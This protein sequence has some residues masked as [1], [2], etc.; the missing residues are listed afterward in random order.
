MQMSLHKVPSWF[1]VLGR[2]NEPFSDDLKFLLHPSAVGV[3]QSDIYDG[4]RL[5]MA[6][7]VKIALFVGDR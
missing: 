2:I 4:V 1:L 3:S 5:F 7:Y 6:L